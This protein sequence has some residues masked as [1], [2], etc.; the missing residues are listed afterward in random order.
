MFF[1]SQS[2][3][4]G[5]GLLYWLAVVVVYCILAFLGGLIVSLATHGMKGPT[6]TVRTVKTGIRD[7]LLV[8][9]KRI[10]AVATL[11]FKEAWRRK[12]F[13][14]GF[15]FIALY[16]FGGW[17]LGNADAEKP[18]KPYVTFVMTSIRWN[19][20]PMA[21]L[22]SCWGLPADIKAR[23]LHTVVTKPV[24]RS[25]IVMGRMLGYSAVVTLVLVVTAV[26]GYVWIQRQVPDRAKDQLIARVPV[27]GQLGFLDKS[28][29]E[30]RSGVN[31]GDVW[32][33][34]SY[35]EGLT[36]ARAIWKFEN[37]NVQRLKSAGKIRVEQ[38]FE[39]FRSYK[40]EIREQVRYTLSVVNPSR[41]LRV[42]V[43]T[44]PVQEF[45]VGTEDA[46]VEIP[47]QLTYRDSYDLDAE[48]KTVDLFDD[49][50]DN[51]ALT[52]EIG[53]VDEQQYLG[54]ARADLFVRLPDESFLSTY[55]RSI[56][57]L[58]LLVVLVVLIGTAGSC[59]LK[60][61]VAT[62]LT[63][64]LIVLGQSLRASM[65]D[66]LVQLTQTGKV[67]GGGMF[68]SVYRLATQMNVQTPLPDN[69]GTTIIKTVDQGIF[70]MLW[71]V[72]ATIPNLTYFDANQFVANGFQVPWGDALLPALATTLGYLIPLI[73]LGYFSLQL[74]ELEHK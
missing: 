14:V 22:V 6:I 67:L 60:G 57:S 61:P 5:F 12:A 35:I 21:I 73:I 68:E 58:W 41:D 66:M 31:V 26:V 52:I 55:T 11:T 18:A 1:D 45:S 28:G 40:G 17:F 69:V 56:L 19:L 62:L 10:S 47:Q 16:M 50:I 37:L 7:L 49:I 2:F 71:G 13:M 54:V 34:R 8:S 70:H 36:N 20:L 33:Y 59:F 44:F 25:E 46:V 51:G 15:L 29:N 64:S 9:G 43:G 27:Y 48:E 3:H 24:R 53:C 65:N 38:S 30:T 63:A 32:E 42:L 4:L 72:Q 39:A 74:R 23:S